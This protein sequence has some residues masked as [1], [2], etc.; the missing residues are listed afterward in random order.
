MD[1]LAHIKERGMTVA[2]VA[3]IAGVSRVAVYALR[4][5]KH[6]PALETVI[7]VAR[8]M[9]VQPSQIRPELTE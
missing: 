6:K 2:S 8:A 3:R 1:I 5:P 7:S 9:G 4:N